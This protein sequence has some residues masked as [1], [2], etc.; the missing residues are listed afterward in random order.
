M[1]LDR[2]L[3]TLVQQ[4]VDRSLAGRPSSI[5]RLRLTLAVVLAALAFT[6]WLAFGG[7]VAD[8][9]YNPGHVGMA[10]ASFENNCIAC[11]DGGGNKGFSKQVSDTACLKCHDA[12]PHHPNQ[13]VAESKD[14]LAASSHVVAVRDS[15]RPESMQV[16]SANCVACHREHRGEDALIAKADSNCTVCHTSLTT[17]VASGTKPRV[18]DGVTKF[19]TAHHPDFGRKLR[20]SG[21]LTQ[22]IADPTQLRFN[23]SYH[24]RDVPKIAAAGCVSCHSASVSESMASADAPPFATPKDGQLFKQASLTATDGKYLQPVNF[25][26]HCISCHQLDVPAPTIETEIDDE[27]VTR[28][29]LREDDPSR[30]SHE[31]VSVIRAEVR[32]MVAKGMAQLV[33][34]EI[35]TKTGDDR[36]A[37]ITKFEAGKQTLL[38]QFARTLSD[39]IATGVGNARGVEAGKF[40]SDD[41][42]KGDLDAFKDLPESIDDADDALKTNLNEETITDLLV[43]DRVLGAGQSCVKCHAIDGALPSL[44]SADKTFSA[45]FNLAIRPTKIPDTP[46]RWFPSSQFDHRKHR[47][48]SCVDCHGAVSHA[49]LERVAKLPDG[50]DQQKAAKSVELAKVAHTSSV[51]M[52]SVNSCVSCHHTPN[53]AG[54]GAGGDCATCHQFHDRTKE[55]QF[56][57]PAFQFGAVTPPAADAK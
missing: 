24:L 28:R 45:A 22:P 16:R 31:D 48:M 29:L 46:R 3:K 53:A 11:H 5:K 47:N 23:H 33:A 50:D 1:A 57:S 17:A 15:S 14:Q 20:A 18:A 6:Y 56:R 40:L 35:G 39:G 42:A 49:N 27:K 25:A 44:K 36:T 30:L 32:Q 7:P 21:D 41:L 19:D 34:E 9:L 2:S 8:R 37:A 51:L 43:A 26:R 55:I 13:L 12:A 38:L 52:P 10:H 54:R 4:R